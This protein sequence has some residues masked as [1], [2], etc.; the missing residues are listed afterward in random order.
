MTHRPR[1]EV[2][3]EELVLHGFSPADRH[4]VA[5]ALQSELARQL[6]DRLPAALVD[7]GAAIERVDAGTVRVMNPARPASVGTE[8]AGAITRAL[9][10]G[11]G[12][13]K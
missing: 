7:G 8:V 13:Q 9:G 11:L 4:L 6:G 2:H 10:G 1:V 12:S 5:E 3:I